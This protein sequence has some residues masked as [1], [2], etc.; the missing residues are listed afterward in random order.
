MFSIFCTRSSSSAVSYVDLQCGTS[1]PVNGRETIVFGSFSVH[2]YKLGESDVSTEHGP[3]GVEAIEV[4]LSIVQQSCPLN[5]GRLLPSA[6][7]RYK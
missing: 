6:N 3:G 7:E 5:V 1:S 4:E 2:A